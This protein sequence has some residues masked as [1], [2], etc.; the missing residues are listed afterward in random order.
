MHDCQLCSR[1]VWPHK[2]GL[3]ALVPPAYSGSFLRAGS[4]CY[5]LYDIQ[6]LC[7]FHTCMN[8]FVTSR[9]QASIPLLRAIA[10]QELTAEWPHVLL[11]NYNHAIQQ[12]Q[13]KMSLP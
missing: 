11:F 5:P 2:R 12:T 8:T 1:P 10:A 7:G 3:Q 4:A 9:L 6:C 13:Q